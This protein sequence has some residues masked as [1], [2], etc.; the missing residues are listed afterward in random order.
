MTGVPNC[1]FSALFLIT[2]ETE[3]KSFLSVGNE[4]GESLFFYFI[5]VLDRHEKKN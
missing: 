4:R 5:T 1:N 2:S 3:N